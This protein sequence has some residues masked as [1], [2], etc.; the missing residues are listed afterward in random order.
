MP[1]EGTLY[2]DVVFRNA[3]FLF[4]CLGSSLDHFIEF[5]KQPEV[6]R[7]ANLEGRMGE[8]PL[9]TQTS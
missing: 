4:G 5:V 8:K 3:Y 6:T 9:M 2:S 1:E 7:P